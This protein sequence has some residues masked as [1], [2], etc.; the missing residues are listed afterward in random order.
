MLLAAVGVLIS[1]PDASAQDD[2]VVNDEYKVEVFKPKEWQQST[3]NEK[4][5]AIFTHPVSQSQIE[6][7]PTKLMTPDVANVFFSTF[8]KT[9]TESSFEQQS[10]AQDKIG[11]Y[12]GTKTTYKFT[13]A[14]V[15]LQV[16]VFQ[17]VRESTAWLVVGYM[18]Q[19][20]GDKVKEAYRWTIQKI[21]FPAAQ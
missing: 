19:T 16:V 1:H 7:V 13:H 20:D 15:T 4:A 5:V 17:F 8:H 14:S 9:L 11:D 10:Q 12:E 21:D 18:Q 6:V 2:K 3:G